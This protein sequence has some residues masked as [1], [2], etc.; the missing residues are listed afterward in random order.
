MAVLW[1]DGFEVWGNSDYLS[2]AYL[3]GSTGISTDAR[4]APGIRSASFSG[5]STLTTPS[6]TTTTNEWYLGIGIKVT[7]AAVDGI[8]FGRISILTG[9][10]EQVRLEFRSTLTGFVVRLVR[11][12]TVI[13]TSTTEWSFNVWRYFELKLVVRGGSNGEY[14]LR[15]NEQTEAS[16]TAT[17]V[18]LA[19]EGTDGADAFEFGSV[20]N[21]P[22]ISFVADDLYILDTSGTENVDFRG[23]SVMFAIYPTADGHQNDFTPTPAGDNFSTIDDPGTQSPNTND[24]V[25]SDMNGHQDFFVFEDLPTTGIGTIFS[26]KFSA[27][28][29]MAAVGSRTLRVLYYDGVMEFAAPDDFTVNGVAQIEYPTFLE[30][31]P[32]TGTKWVKADVDAGEFGFEVV[33]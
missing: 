28:A 33:S 5:G 9:I 30:V 16:M 2:Q 22:G 24:F 8:T 32:D 18:N 27:G 7:G 12:S 19:E 23:D 3:A 25:S 11:G 13:A 17:G 6:L 31:N 10:A 21:G 26:L 4:V 14:E 20:S 29:Q 1:H 15:V